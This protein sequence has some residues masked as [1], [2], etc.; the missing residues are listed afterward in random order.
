MCCV[1]RI[2]GTEFDSKAYSKASTLPIDFVSIL[3]EIW[4]GRSKPSKTNGVG[5]TV[6]ERDLLSEQIEDAIAF[7]KRYESELERIAALSGVEIFWLDFGYECRLNGTTVVMQGEYL[8]VELLV[9][10][11]KLGIGIALSLY[12]ALQENEDMQ[13]IG[14]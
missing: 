6:S 1:L 7:L 5:C 12:P 11:G 14:Q 4:E 13:S 2:S 9:L 8:P 10:A 3:G